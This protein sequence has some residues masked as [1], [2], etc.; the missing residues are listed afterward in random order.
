LVEHWKSVRMVGNLNSADFYC[1][2]LVTDDI[3]IPLGESL[4]IERFQPLWNVLIEGFG[5]HDPGSGRQK[6]VCSM[7]DT[8]HPGRKLAATLPPNPKNAAVLKELIADFFAGR[9]VPTI[10]P[11]QAVIYEES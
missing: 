3:W 2:Y 7:W 8:L 9:P 1:R 10:S 6:Q 5:I 11:K 4:L